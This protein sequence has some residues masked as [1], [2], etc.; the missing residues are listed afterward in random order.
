[1]DQERITPQELED[2]KEQA[3]TQAHEDATKDSKI[4]LKWTVIIVLGILLIIIA[5]VVINGLSGIGSD[6]SHTIFGWSTE[7]S[8]NPENKSGFRNLLKLSLTAI[9]LWI[10]IEILKRKN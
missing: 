1:M 2:I 10:G 7:A 3:E 5:I 4:Y 6:A 9:F 8:I